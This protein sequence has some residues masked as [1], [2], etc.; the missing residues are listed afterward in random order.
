MATLRAFECL[1]AVGESGSVTQAAASLHMSQPALSHQISALER[2]IGAALFERRARGVRLTPAGRA[3]AQEARSALHHAAL[4]ISTGRRV[5]RGEAGRLRIASA[6]TMTNWLLTS[7]MRE[8][9]LQYPEVDFELS[10]FSSADRMDRFLSDGHADLIVGPRPT[11]T[12]HHVELLG[13]EEMVVV[14]GGSHLFADE[15]S[16]GVAALTTEA[17]IHYVPE[18]GL[19]VWVDELAALHGATLD[20]VLRT[21]SPRTAAGLAAAGIG[22][23]VVPVSALVG[24]SE[25]TVRPLR[26]RVLRDIIVT[27]ATPTD[28]LSRRFVADLR[29]RGLP[30]GGRAVYA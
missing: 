1:V 26:P 12:N 10:E 21:R 15:T 25:G 5:G 13:R 22:V 4:A 18:N 8:W 7:A 24:R 29:V 9:R 28:E 30:D 23:T 11:T 14:A 16:I 3:V 17:F 19:S 27:V 20:P 2:E 6:E